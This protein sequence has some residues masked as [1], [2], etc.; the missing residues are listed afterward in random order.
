MSAVDE[1]ED[2]REVEEAPS[3]LD[4]VRA[5]RKQSRANRPITIE[6]PNLGGVYARYRP[7]SPDYAE[8]VLRQGGKE[9]VLLPNAC[10]ALS[11]F[12][13]EIVVKRDG[14]L[15]PLVESTPEDPRP[16]TFDYRLAKVLDIEPLPSDASPQ[17]QAH[18]IVIEM[19]PAEIAVVGQSIQLEQQSTTGQRLSDEELLGES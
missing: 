4:E 2:R 18:H 12:C 15:V 7:I 16:V 19:F 3:F 6:I 10:D 17:E 5:R 9:H 13:I 14:Q 1:T 8:R 11:E